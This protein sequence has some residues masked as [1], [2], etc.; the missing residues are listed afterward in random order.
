M[1][2]RQL[3]TE[4]AELVRL[5]RKLRV[6]LYPTRPQQL[7]ELLLCRDRFHALLVAHRNNEDRLLYPRLARHGDPAVA[8]LA[9]RFT[10]EMGALEDE[11]GRWM[12]KWT[13]GAIAPGWDAFRT[14]TEELLDALSVRIVRENRELYPL[15]ERAA[16]AA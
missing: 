10:R 15:I 11:V 3:R 13:P 14:E 12:A 4:H 5:S 6:H 7:E 16:M 1:P 9:A 8:A 2:M